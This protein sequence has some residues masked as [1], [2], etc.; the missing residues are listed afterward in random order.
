MDGNQL[1]WEDVSEGQELPP[2]AQKVGYME[3]NRFAG[4][5]NELVPI[6]MD[7][8]YAKNVAKLPDV[9]I[10]G[11]LKLAYIA[12]ALT[13][14]AGDHGWVRKIAIEYRK[15]DMVNTTITAKAKVTKK[16]EQNGNHLVDLHVWVE[17]EAG[18]VTTPGSAVV[19]LPSRS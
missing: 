2:Y 6:H 14:W 15:M 9:I 3:L 13:G 19:A 10:M 16:Y 18:E 12:N 17:N 7:P 4:A 1:Y 8:D 5:N 11:N